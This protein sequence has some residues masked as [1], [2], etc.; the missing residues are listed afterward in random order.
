MACRQ[1]LRNTVGM[2]SHTDPVTVFLVED[3][4]AVRARIA[5]MFSAPQ[6]T[7]VGAAATP[8]GAIAGI[9]AQQPDVVVLDVGLLGGSGLDVLQA[10]RPQLPGVAFVVFSNN[11]AAPYRRRYLAAGAADFLDKS[12]DAARLTGA[13]QA[14]AGRRPKTH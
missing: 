6:A 13:V 10:V 7:V 3:S 12:T 9:L 5:E 2:L 11:A 8:S 14:A 4:A 1:R